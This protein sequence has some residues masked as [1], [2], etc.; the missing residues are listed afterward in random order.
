MIILDIAENLAA[1]MIEELEKALGTRGK[2][3]GKY[4]HFYKC[5]VANKQDVE[6][7]WNIVIQN[8]GPVH[9]LVNNAARATGK[10]ID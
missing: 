8:H 7:V 9:I 1:N 5:N 6:R 10:S 4:V 3:K 2:Q